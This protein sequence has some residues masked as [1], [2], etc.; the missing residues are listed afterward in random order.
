LLAIA[1]LRR[2]FEKLVIDLIQLFYP[3]AASQESNPRVRYAIFRVI[4]QFSEQSMDFTFQWPADL[5]LPLFEEARSSEL[6]G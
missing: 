1:E 5:I 6:D 2:D 3:H 4:T